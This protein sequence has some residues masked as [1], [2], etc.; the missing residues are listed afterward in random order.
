MSKNPTMLAVVKSRPEPDGL[1]LQEVPIPPVGSKDILVRVMATSICGTDVH[2]WKWTLPWSKR[3]KLP[4]IIGHEFSGV[5]EESG[6]QISHIV[7]GD[8]VSAETH[9]VCGTCDQCRT[10]NSHICETV[11]IIGVDTP[12]SFAQYVAFPAENAIVNPPTLPHKIAT[13]QEPFGNAVHTALSTNLAGK[14]VL[15]TGCGPIGLMSIGIAKA[16]GAIAVFATDIN[17]YRIDLARKMEADLVINPQETNVTEMIMANTGWKGVD[18]LLE[19]SGNHHALIEGLS[20]VKNGGFA[21]LL[22]LPEGNVPLDVSNLIV[23]KGITVYG[24][25]GRLMYESW[26]QTSKL[27]DAGRV[28]ISPLIRPEHQLPLEAFREGLEIMAAGQCGKVI[29]YP[30]GLPTGTGAGGASS[31][32]EDR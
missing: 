22:G 23:L 20:L 6:E 24:V 26:Q 11:K 13:I 9:I 7:P 25:A 1:E 12:G 10:G 17:P 29:L 2:I 30:N 28:D 8:R 4:H 18:V 31:L 14:T 19:M 3:V 5:V 32:K 15:I 16:V 27:L 21:A